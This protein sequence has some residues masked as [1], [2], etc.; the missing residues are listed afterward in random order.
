MCRPVHSAREVDRLNE[1]LGVMYLCWPLSASWLGT[2]GAIP[3]VASTYVAC[4]HADVAPPFG[5]A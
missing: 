2:S 4:W 5:S 1:P 3:R